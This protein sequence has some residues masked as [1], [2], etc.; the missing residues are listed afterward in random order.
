MAEIGIGIALA[1]LTA[2]LPICVG[3][4]GTAVAMSSIGSAAMGYLAEK[5][6]SAGSVMIF[7]AL[8]ETI[9]ILG[10]VLSFILVGSVST[11]VSGALAAG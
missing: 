8:P 4:I 6:G 2:A 10:F 3:G 5:E 9:V 1:F 7:I 11:A